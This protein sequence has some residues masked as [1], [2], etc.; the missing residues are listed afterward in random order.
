MSIVVGDQAP[1]FEL[2]GPKGNVSLSE[3]LKS[4]KKGVVVYFYPRANT[5]GCTT[6]ACD[7][8]DNLA[9]LESYG[10]QVVGISPDP[11]SKLEKFAADHEL[12]FLLLSDENH[13]VMSAYGAWGPKQNYGKTVIGTIRSTFVIDPKGKV[14][15]A[16]SNVRAKGH[17]E[18]L[19]KELE[20]D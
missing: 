10:Y 1:A 20:L 3:L 16:K 4:S 2:S 15:L 5:P 8:R 12:P 11:L 14:V 18:R 7:F 9:R 19:I 6:E 13:E 17:V